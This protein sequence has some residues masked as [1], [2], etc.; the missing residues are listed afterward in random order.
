MSW[1]EALDNPQALAAVFSS[2][3]QLEVHELLELN[4]RRD[5]QKL[6]VR[7]SLNRFPDRP[8]RRWDERANRLHVNMTFHIA[9]VHHLSGWSFTNTCVLEVMPTSEGELAFRME[10]SALFLYGTCAQVRV[11]SLV[12]VQSDG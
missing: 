10:G 12:A 1:L 3:D 7:V 11:D 6:T 2:L 9:R 5:D 8:A 4:L